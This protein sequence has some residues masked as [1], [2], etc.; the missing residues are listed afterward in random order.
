MFRQLGDELV[1]DEN[2]LLKKGLVIRLLVLPN[3][4]AEVRE[5]LKWIR[6]ELSS[7]VSV[8]LMAQYYP[9]N[10]AVTDARYVLLSRKISEREWVSANDAL[11]EFGFESGFIQEFKG[12]AH[13][14]RPDFSN[15][16]KPFEDIRDFA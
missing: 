5:S 16:E 13:Y 1:F 11:A 7:K 8:S 3:E 9:T 6:D 14:Y 10:K 12:A 2:G 4:I 15:R